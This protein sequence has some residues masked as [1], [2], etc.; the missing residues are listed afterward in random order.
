MKRA[1]KWILGSVV[2]VAGLIATASGGL[3]PTGA[4]AQ[5][6]SPSSST[7][8][9]ALPP[10]GVVNWF[11][12]LSGVVT[13]SLYNYWMTTLLYH[14]LLMFHSNGRVAWQHSIVD[15]LQVS[16]QGTVYTLSLN[17]KWRWSDGTPVT[18][19]DLLFTWHLIQAASSPKAPPPWPYLQAGVGDIPQGIQSMTASGAYT[20][21]IHLKAGVNRNWFIDKGLNQL[22]PL[23]QE[24]FN[25]YPNQPMAELRWLATIASDPA[26]PPFQVID[27]P[28]RY[29]GGQ[30]GQ[31]YVFV[32][33]SLYA[34]HKPGFTRL[35]WEETAS[36][37]A[38]YALYRTHAIDWG[39]L[40]A[41]D[42][43]R[44]SVSLTAFYHLTTTYA[45]SYKNLL[46][47]LNTGAPGHIDRLFRQLPI[48]QAL[49]LGIDQSALVQDVYR[50]YAVPEV[51][52]LAPKPPTWFYDPALQ[53]TYRF[54]IAQ[55]QQLLVRAGWRLDRGVV[56]Q[57]GQPLAFTLQYVSGSTTIADEAQL[58]QQWW[59]QEGI[60]VKLEPLSM[61][62]LLGEKPS[63]WQAIL[64]LGFNYGRGYPSG[65]ELFGAAG[66]G[67]NKEGYQNATMTHLIA[68]TH[69]AAPSE[70]VS[71]QRLY[72][73][74]AYVAQQLPV[75]LVP[76]PAQI[77]VTAKPLSEGLAGFSPFQHPWPQ[78]WVLKP[79]SFQPPAS[80]KHRPASLMAV[81]SS[82]G[83]RD[84]P[85]W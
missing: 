63:Q 76:D 1:R 57:H 23:P 58:I 5:G 29:A 31:D 21:V 35:V 39:Y 20:V 49:Q 62:A 11:F 54:D 6:F 4:E 22:T 7:V 40:P 34:G 81:R 26:S 3:L 73:Y 67:V 28:F 56:V 85:R 82:H 37:A 74:E 27:G 18:A 8:V 32:L 41:E 64:G 65:G 55:G 50:G 45:V 36:D 70:A 83:G 17:P 43:G 60:G 2:A 38:L 9:A 33:N 48:R 52:A 77:V 16:D 78:Y 66:Q 19:K 46:L 14:P 79:T 68:A 59:A 25:H 53:P 13:D 51:T 75:L 10:G 15:H 44:A 12:P 30:A 72:Q 71:A 69:Q 42:T 61:A 24:V 80:T 47:N 84:G